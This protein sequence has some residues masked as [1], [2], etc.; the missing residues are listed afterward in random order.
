MPILN[1]QILQGQTPDRKRAFLKAA[2]DAVVSS[3]PAPLSSVRVFL[4]ELAP[5]NVLVSG[6]AD[7]DAVLIQVALISGRTEEA[8]S[9]LIAA[10]NEATVQTLGVDG[11]QIRVILFDVPNTDMGMANGLSA[12]SQGR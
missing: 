12:K 9:A 10:L 11:A 7:I 8:K 6:Q 5:E 3:L 4:A 2:T 1:V